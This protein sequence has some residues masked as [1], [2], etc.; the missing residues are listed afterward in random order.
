MQKQKCAAIIRFRPRQKHS[1][2]RVWAFFGL[3][4]LFWA[5]IFRLKPQCP[6]PPLPQ[7]LPN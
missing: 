1:S 2:P 7:Q 5:R 3:C 6:L 4:L